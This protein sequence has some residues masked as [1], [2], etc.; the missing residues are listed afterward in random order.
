MRDITLEDTIRIG[1]T[2]RAFATGIPGTLGGTPALS[3]LE[4]NNA[5]PITGG[6]SVS[7]DRASVTGLNE[8][9]VVATTGNGYEAGKGYTVYISAGTVGGVSVVGEVVGQFTIAASASAVDLAN[10]TDGLGA[11]EVNLNQIIGQ[12]A[13]VAGGL[14]IRTPMTSVTVIQGSEQNLA[15]ASTSDDSRWTGDDDGSGAEF[16]FRCTPANSEAQ[17]GDIH[18]EG[19]YDEPSGASNGATLEVY[20]FNSSVWDSVLTL[21]NAS[22]DGT[23]DIGL[24]EHH[25]APGSGTIETVPHTH[26]DVLIK[27]SQ[28]TQETGNACLLIDSMHV[29]FIESTLTILNAIQVVTDN[30]PDSGALTTIGTDTARLTAVRAAVLT[31]WINNGRLD[32]LLDAITPVGPTK[33]EMDTAHGLLATPSQV[34]AQV[35]DVLR[36][37]TSS[38]LTAGAPTATP[39]FEEAIMY[40]YQRFRNKVTQTAT[41]TKMYKDDAATVLT[42]ATVADDGT[43]ATK[44]EFGAP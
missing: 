6:V 7:V 17:P 28:D 36:T 15:N 34:N 29:G 5:T 8:A 16:I 18:F 35:V 20:N 14:A 40:L 44:G 39:T 26:G 31:D 25:S 21:S 1:F 38:E 33:A 9:T 24:V 43:T 12:I 22:S 23:Y 3:V 42:K 13:G 41:E 2:T 10:D 4:E 32:A 27:F 37:D 11:I 19:Y 30:L